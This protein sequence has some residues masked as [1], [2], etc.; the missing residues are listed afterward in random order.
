MMRHLATSAIFAGALAVGANAQDYYTICSESF[1]YAAG[2]NL[3]QQNGGEGWFVS[4]YSGPSDSDAVIIAPGIDAVGNKLITNAQ[5]GG[6]YRRPHTGTWA[7][8][9]FNGEFG[10]DGTTIWISFDCKRT[11][12][13]TDDYGGLSLFTFFGGE[14]L[15]LGSPYQSYQWGVAGSAGQATAPGSNVDLQSR[16]VYRIDYLPGMERV[17]LWVNPAVD[18]PQGTPDVDTMV[19]DHIWNEIRLQSGAGSG[20]QVGYEFDDIVVE[21]EQEPSVYDYDTGC[22]GTGGF[23]PDLD[24]T[25][26]LPPSA[27]NAFDLSVSG[28]L[29]GSTALLF[30]GFGKAKLPLGG[31]CFLNLATIIP[32]PVTLPLGGAGAG[33]GSILLPATMP[34]GTTGLIFG[35]QTFVI[36]A[37]VPMGFSASPGLQVEVF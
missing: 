10:A 6:S 8:H 21:M 34:A 18:H 11:A 23:T 22:A 3:G 17:R 37:G 4:W 33:D 31:G 26:A 7:K 32:S 36:D 5:D 27:G 15:F 1:D 30:I 29:G 16:L 28:G 9:T 2:A 12:G 25:S 20:A 14:K 35:L 24:V 19:A 13:G